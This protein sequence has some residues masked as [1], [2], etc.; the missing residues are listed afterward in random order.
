MRNSQW[1]AIVEDEPDV[2][3]LISYHLEKS[4][5]KTREFRGGK[6]LL[7]TL[8]FETPSLII[9]DLMLPDIDGLEVCK[10]N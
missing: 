1:I 3:H 8:S 7:E 5:F 2:S 4:G 9:L 10:K 6:P